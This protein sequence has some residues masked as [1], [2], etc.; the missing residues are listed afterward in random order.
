MSYVETI[1]HRTLP[2]F[3]QNSFW[4]LSTLHSLS[5]RRGVYLEYMII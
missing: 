3:I 5:A 1:S 4:I 2:Q